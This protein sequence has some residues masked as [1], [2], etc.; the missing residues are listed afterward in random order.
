MDQVIYGL[1]LKKLEGNLATSI[2]VRRTM[3][4]IN[5]ASEALD[6]LYGV[7]S[8]AS[9]KSWLDELPS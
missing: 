5:Y 3:N 1:V 8:P 6:E 2:R 9:K 7:G 4:R